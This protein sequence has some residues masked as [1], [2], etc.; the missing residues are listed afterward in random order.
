VDIDFKP[1]RNAPDKPRGNGRFPWLV[2]LILTTATLVGLFYLYPANA[3]LPAPEGA[4]ATLSHESPPPPEPV[5]QTVTG[6]IQSGDTLTSLLGSWL[7]SLQLLE[8]ERL[9]RPVF[10]IS[11]IAAG[12]PY[13]I[14]TRD[15]TLSEFAYDINSDE[16]YLLRLDENGLSVERRDIPYVIETALVEGTISTSLFEAV[17]E[18]GEG[19][20]LAIEL[21]GI[22][23]WDIDFIRDIRVGDSFR[24][25]VEKRYRD[26]APAGY[27]HILAAEFVNQGESFRGIRFQDGDRAASYYDAEGRNLRKAFLRAPLSFTRISSGF[28]FK[29][30]HPITKTWKAHPAI[31]YAAPRGTPIMTVGDGTII[32]IGQDR[33]NGRYIKIRHNSTYETLYLHMNAFAKGMQKG[34]RLSQGQTIG[35]VGSTGLATGPHL[36]F[37]MYKNGSPVNPYKVKVP[38]AKEI[39]KENLEAFIAWAAPLMQRLDQPLQVAQ[40]LA[41]AEDAQT[42]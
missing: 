4:V 17:E 32:K 26:G 11:R 28:T 3:L 10:P 41:G 38:A 13:V 20:E 27:G 9:S 25:L 1:P 30:F 7:D 6:T 35:Y 8:V 21:A 37:R 2:A 40:N 16:Q 29:R 18:I 22:F 5:V 24:A 33:N 15:G 36:C 31:D 42:R 23:A 14:T 19:A 39:S 12:R 34:K